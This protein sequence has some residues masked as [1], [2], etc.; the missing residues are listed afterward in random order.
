MSA[1]GSLIGGS[2]AYIALG[3]ACAVLGWFLVRTKR[4][5][6][7]E[8][9]IFCLSNIIAWVCMWMLWIC[10]WLHQWH[11]IIVPTQAHLAELDKH[12]A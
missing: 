1:A 2:F 12:E 11:P 7:D 4:L 3:L 9:Q 8:G 10:T 5:T 6:K